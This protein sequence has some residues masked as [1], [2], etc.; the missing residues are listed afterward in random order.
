MSIDY[1]QLA[2]EVNRMDAAAS[3]GA[4]PTPS[5][6]PSRLPL[7]EPSLATPGSPIAQ[8]QE[9]ISHEPTSQLPLADIARVAIPTAIQ[10]AASFTPLGSVARLSPAIAKVAPY[11]I[12]AA[13]GV[14]GMKANEALGL[15]P[16][17]EEG[18]YYA[19]AGF[20][21]ALRGV[22]SAAR[23]FATNQTF[24]ARVIKH[25]MAKV[26]QIDTLPE[27][28]EMQSKLT[29]TIP[30]SAK[31]VEATGNQLYMMV[32]KAGDPQVVPAHT[33]KIAQEIDATIHGAKSKALEKEYSQLN[34]IAKDLWKADPVSFT[35]MWDRSKL[36]SGL[37]NKAERAG[38][39][40]TARHLLKI[41]DALWKDMDTATG[42][43]AGLLKEANRFWRR[44]A[45]REELAEVI[46]TKGWSHTKEGANVEVNAKALLDWMEK[47][48]TGRS[49]QQ[50]VIKTSPA[51]EK[52]V[53]AIRNTLK[54]VSL[55]NPIGN[56][57]WL[58]YTSKRVLSA[59][60]IGGG[61][62]LGAATG[63]GAPAMMAGAVVGGGL[64]KLPEVFS[65]ALLTPWGRQRIVKSLEVTG[66]HLS[67]EAATW[68]G[69][70]LRATPGIGSDAMQGLANEMQTR[71][72]VQ[73]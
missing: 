25:E 69:T 53:Q 16:P 15:E 13:A 47:T 46:Q 60:G 31:E 6:M 66:R 28:V 73:P 14:M 65:A 50:D 62:A 52:E 72:P 38:D 8:R 7:S 34:A 24:A 44:K 49:W 48:P 27:A 43:Q 71:M 5:A 22:T 70:A 11:A 4:E 56:K 33:A 42:S 41:K 59:V 19:A 2:D 39:D 32:R 30:Q 20:P 29:A 55:I 68:L 61:A 23:S 54:D 63:G 51:G 12:D 10:G 67:D 40:E 36:I 17:A 57:E 18:D 58:S 21:T 37:V 3:A 1:A 35:T 9:R 26:K 64:L 45:A